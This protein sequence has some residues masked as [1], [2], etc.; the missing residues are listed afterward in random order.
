MVIFVD[1]HKINVYNDLYTY[2]KCILFY[3]VKVS[4]Y[5]FIRKCK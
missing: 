4:G 5:E 3:K 2:L 1:T